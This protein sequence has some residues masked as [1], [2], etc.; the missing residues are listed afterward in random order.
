MN[1]SANGYNYYYH[2]SLLEDVFEIKTC[3][4]NDAMWYV[5]LL[6]KYI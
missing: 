1:I 3:Y 6:I 4:L 5:P 2:Q